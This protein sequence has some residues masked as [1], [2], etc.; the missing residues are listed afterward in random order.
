MVEGEE[1]G[2]KNEKEGEKI[3]WRRRIKSSKGGER[4]GGEE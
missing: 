2:E 3:R 1:V 4:G